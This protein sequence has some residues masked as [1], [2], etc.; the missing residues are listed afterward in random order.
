MAAKNIEAV[1]AEEKKVDQEIERIMSVGNIRV[2]NSWMRRTVEVE[3]KKNQETK[4]QGERIDPETKKQ[5]AVDLKTTLVEGVRTT[6]TEEKIGLTTRR[7]GIADM[8][9]TM[10]EEEHNKTL[11]RRTVIEERI[12]PTWIT[13]TLDIEIA[14]KEEKH[15]RII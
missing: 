10:T 3:E 8:R 7:V 13:E 15:N 11:M 1:A 2:E 9:R 4:K 5:E 12:D 14:V 6:V